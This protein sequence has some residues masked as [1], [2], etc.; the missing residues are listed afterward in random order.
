MSRGI[1]A[2][3]IKM[4]EDSDTV[5]F[6]YGAY[7][8]NEAAFRNEKHVRDGYITVLKSCFTEPEIHTKIK[9]LPSGKKRL[10]TKRIPVSVDYIQLLQEEKIKVE[11]CSFGWK[12]TDDRFEVDIMACYLLSKLFKLYQEEGTIPNE[13]YYD[14]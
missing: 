8:L 5:V 1:G 10:I 7:N 9:K 14:V 13:V 2:K 3:A 6:E 11:N 12:K 4:L